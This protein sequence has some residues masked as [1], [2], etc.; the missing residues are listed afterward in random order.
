M[1]RG[2]SAG[3][4]SG[5]RAEGASGRPGAAPGEVEGP[6]PSVPCDS[7]MAELLRGSLHVVALSLFKHRYSASFQPRRLL[8]GS[9]RGHKIFPQRSAQGGASTWD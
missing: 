5:L 9:L 8:S 1:P 6:G 7:P 2:G 3:S 4:R